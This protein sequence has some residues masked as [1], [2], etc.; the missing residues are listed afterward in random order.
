MKKTGILMLTYETPLFIDNLMNYVDNNLYI[1]PKHPEKISHEFKKYII[2]NIVET[3]WGNISIVNATIN[4]IEQALL[5]KSLEYFYLISGDTFILDEPQVKPFSTFDTSYHKEIYNVNK[6]NIYKSSQ[7]F[8]ITRKDA[9]IIIDTKNKYM[10]IFNNITKKDLKGSAYDETYFLTVLKN[11]SKTEYKYIDE[12]TT[13]VRWMTNVV[14]KHPIIYNKMTM[15]NLLYLHSSTFIRKCFDT[16][17]K[18]S[19][20]VKPELYVFYI[21]SK[22]NQKDIHDY[23]LHE[24][25][26]MVV[27]SIDIKDIDKVILKNAFNIIQIIWKFYVENVNSLKTSTL[28]TCWDK[29]IFV[30]E[31]NNIYEIYDNTKNIVKTSFKKLDIQIM[32]DKKDCSKIKKS[33]YLKKIED[34]SN[35]YVK[36]KIANNEI[37]HVSKITETMTFIINTI[38]SVLRIIKICGLKPIDNTYLFLVENMQSC[39]NDIPVLTLSKNEG[40][41]NTFLFPPK[42]LISCFSEEHVYYYVYKMFKTFNKLIE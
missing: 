31:L 41:I 7:W 24:I 6:L 3:E 22:T 14:T 32:N 11:E 35:M 33:L 26:Y 15:L 27:T 25:D 4:L 21:G 38:N 20:K 37:V 36:I 39:E 9:N 42:E 16:F 5:D 2:Q 30:D 17:D 8:G 23:L 10:N 40:C 18:H 29:I 1:H 34:V 12:K 13:Y 28:T 19:I